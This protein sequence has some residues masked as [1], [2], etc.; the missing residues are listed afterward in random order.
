MYSEHFMHCVL[1]FNKQ[2]PLHIFNVHRK[3]N[4][5]SSLLDDFK[6]VFENNVKFKNNFAENKLNDNDI[7][8]DKINVKCPPGFDREL[9]NILSDVQFHASIDDMDKINNIDIDKNLENCMVVPNENFQNKF[10]VES[11]NKQ[12][13]KEYAKQYFKELA[14]ESIEK[15]ISQFNSAIICGD[16]NIH[17]GSFP[18]IKQY[19]E[20]KNFI[21]IDTSILYAGM[22]AHDGGYY[23]REHMKIFYRSP[24]YN[25]S[26]DSVYFRKNL[27]ISLSSH[28]AIPLI[29]NFKSDVISDPMISQVCDRFEDS[30]NNKY[31]QI[32][33]EIFNNDKINI[34]RATFSSSQMKRKRKKHKKSKTKLL[35]KDQ[36]LYNDKFDIIDLNNNVNLGKSI[37]IFNDLHFEKCVDSVKM[38]GTLAQMNVELLNH[39]KEKCNIINKFIDNLDVLPNS[40]QNNYARSTIISNNLNICSQQISIEL[41]YFIDKYKKYENDKISL[42]ITK[43]NVEDFTK[44]INDQ[45]QLEHLHAYINIIDKVINTFIY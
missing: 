21:E 29:L 24:V 4:R 42:K 40:K 14:V 1:L 25:L 20:S 6:H 17:D 41:D 11:I 32:K 28:I 36:H 22:S 44:I 5:K 43:F 13:C 16:F 27:S 7:K 2:H 9:E 12:Q 39:M 23:K 26:I 3:S 33:N 34:I 37:D 30:N 15:N 31:D 18:G 35:L 45:F 10:N 38:Q 19:L 8:I